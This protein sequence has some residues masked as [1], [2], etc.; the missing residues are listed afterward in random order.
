MLKGLC[1]VY[2][3]GQFDVLTYLSSLYPNLL[4]GYGGH[5]MAAG[6]SIAKEDLDEFKKAIKLV[7][8]N[9]SNK[10][11]TKVFLSD[12]DLKEGD[13]HLRHA[14]DIKASGPRRMG[15]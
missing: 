11:I 6:L 13:I 3:R 9:L 14:Q 7:R 12:G 1:K 10:H 15:L 5:A 4:K 8:K 2:T